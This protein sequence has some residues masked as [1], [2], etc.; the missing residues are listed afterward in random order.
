MK[1]KSHTPAGRVLIGLS[2]PIL[3]TLLILYELRGGA[4][5]ECPFFK[6]TGLYCPGCG[7]GRAV[8]ALIRGDFARSF[9]FN[10]MLY[11]LGAPSFAGVLYEYLRI[12]FFPRRFHPIILP[13]WI[14][15]S[16]L[17]LLFAW[18]ILRNL[19]WFPCFRPG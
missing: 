18:W 1:W 13:R 10:P 8:Q 3:L 19:P 4:G 17:V 2:L 9:R 12:V 7:S 6:L 11:L 15:V 16:L 5:L 14:C